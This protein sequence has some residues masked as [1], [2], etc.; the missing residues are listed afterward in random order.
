MKNVWSK[1]TAMGNVAADIA[2]SAGDQDCHAFKLVSSMRGQY[3]HQ[4][5]YALMRAL[6]VCHRFARADRFVV[7]HQAMMGD[8]QR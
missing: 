6:A 4:M 3:A 2:R 1:I 5:K 8:R 7:T